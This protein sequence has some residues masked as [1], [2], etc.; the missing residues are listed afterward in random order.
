MN[1]MTA[2]REI[3]PA[4]PPGELDA[5]RLAARRQFVAGTAPKQAGHRW[6]LPVLAGGLTAAAAATASGVLVLTGAP[7][8]TPGQHATTGH[9]GTVVTTAWTVRQNAD[10]TVTIQLRQYAD[11][12]GMQRTLRADGIDAIVRPIPW[13][14]R[15]VNFPAVGRQLQKKAN[16]RALPGSAAPTCV[17]ART[18][19]ASAAVQHAAVTIVQQ[20]IP[21]YFIIHPA[22][23]PHRS[24]LFLAFMA[25]VP[26]GT[27]TGNFAM[28]PVVLTD[29]TAPACVPVRLANK[30]APTPELAPK[31]KTRP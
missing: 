10:G 19:N 11:P 27:G 14:L 24:A 9:A 17:Y 2:L 26:A 7:V 22:R 5:M 16:G 29:A 30:A 6:R 20:A 23:I 4:P 28:K 21:A 31:V 25:N 15:T 1:E 13:V 3:R 8:A 18:D 12:A